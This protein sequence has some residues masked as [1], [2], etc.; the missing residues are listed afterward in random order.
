MGNLKIV[1]PE[2][3][4]NLISNPSFETNTTGWSGGGSNTVARSLD[5]CVFGSY[6]LKCTFV[7]SSILAQFTLPTISAS[8]VYVASTWIYIDDAWTGT[9]ISIET[10]LSD[11]VISYTKLWQSGDPVEQW[12]QIISTI[13]TNTD[14]TGSIRI[15]ATGSLTSGHK[16][17]I[18]GVQLENKSTITTFCDGSIDGCEWSGTVHAS[19]STRPKTERSGG[20]IYDFSNDLGIQVENIR[21]AG[22]PIVDNIF[23]DR[24]LVDGQ[25][26]LKT[27]VKGFDISFVGTVTE[28]TLGLYHSKRNQLIEAMRPDADYGDQPFVIQYHGSGI[29][30]HLKV[31]IQS[32]L[33]MNKGGGF[34]ERVNFRFISDEAYWKGFG[35]KTFSGNVEDSG[36]S[37]GIQARLGGLWDSLSLTS[38]SH[39]T[40]GSIERIFHDKDAGI[41]Y[42]GGTFTNFGGNAGAN[43]IAKYDLET[44]SWSRVGSASDLNAK[45]TGFAKRPAGGVYVCGSFTNA[46]GDANADGIA[47]WTGSAWES[48]PAT[49]GTSGSV[50]S[51]CNDVALGKDD[52]LYVCGSF[53]NLAGVTDADGLAVF[54]PATGNWSEVGQSHGLQS[55]AVAVAPNGDLYYGGSWNFSADVG[56]TAF[57]IA[58][59]DGSQWFTMGSGVNSGGIVEDIFVDENGDVYIGGSNIVTVGGFSTLNV[60]KWNGSSWS[61]L[62]SGFTN[63]VQSIVKVGSEIIF[64]GVDNAVAGGISLP[65]GLGAWDGSGWRPMDLDHGAD[66]CDAVENV[67]GELWVGLD[68]VESTIYKAGSVTVTTEG[69]AKSFP[70]IE[71][72][73]FTS[74]DETVRLHSIVNETTGAAMY[75]N[76]RFLSYET[77][78]IELDPGN[79]FMDSSV[80]GRSWNILPTSDIVDF[81]IKPGVDNLISM[82]WERGT[83]AITYTARIIVPTNSWGID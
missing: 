4:T 82:F 6:S 75:F 59:W 74:S 48:V 18:D 33:G 79:R 58:R 21:G 35:E 8:S 62:G 66:D 42:V 1:V 37:G 51:D 27:K 10:T 30:K 64:A 69:N 80:F 73:N 16:I 68:G 29:I 13:T 12:I 5:R 19:Q 2:E 50:G 43:Y 67:N 53:I 44:E 63:G 83:S 45:V 76:H 54:D 11:D 34:A 15:N 23:R 28:D 46:G 17:Y 14:T 9:E 56:G 38:T 32:G 55:Y 70:R 25:E 31:R 52:K 26:F 7:D 78:T 71:M 65:C 57:N 72:K 39:L 22:F 81:F 49:G 24:A 47:A 36:N 3:T 41:V 61:A 60:G 40:F 20:F 77:V